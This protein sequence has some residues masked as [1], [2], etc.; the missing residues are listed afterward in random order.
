MLAHKAMSIVNS[1]INGRVEVGSVHISPFEGV[2]ISDVAIIDDNAYI[3]SDGVPED[4]IF[5]AKHINAL[6]SPKGLLNPNGISIAEAKVSDGF[7]VFVSEPLGDGIGKTT[8]IGRVFSTGEQKQE[9]EKKESNLSL[10][11]RKSRP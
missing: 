8:N 1:K 11:S 4:T 5:R 3:S 9:K 7:F 6:F 2:S 10:S